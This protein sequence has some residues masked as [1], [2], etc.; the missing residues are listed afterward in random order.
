VWSPRGEPLDRDR[1]FR[2][3]RRSAGWAPRREVSVIIYGAAI[4]G[5]VL[6]TR[7]QCAH[8]SC[9][10]QVG[11]RKNGSILVFFPTRCKSISSHESDEA[12]VI[13]FFRTAKNG[14]VASLISRFRLDLGLHP[15]DELRSSPAFRGALGDSG[16]KKCTRNGE[17][18][19]RASCGPDLSAREGGRRPHRLIFR[20]SSSSS[21]IVFRAL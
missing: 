19:F 18:T 10:T 6:G 20:A 13:F 7:D 8:S 21:R 17:E 5:W 15:S 9:G 16:R 12:S 3:D 1:P 14:S 11:H 4:P 2:P